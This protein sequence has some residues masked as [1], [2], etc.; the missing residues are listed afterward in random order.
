MADFWGGFGKGFAPAYE[1]AFTSAERRR[2]KREAEIKRLEEARLDRLRKKLKERADQAATVASYGGM[3]VKG[4]IPERRELPVSRDPSVV[5]GE[6]E[7]GITPE[8]ITPRV[9][10]EDAVSELSDAEL[11]TRSK[12]GPL[13]YTEMIAERDKTRKRMEEKASE[14]LDSVEQQGRQSHLTPDVVA[15]PIPDTLKDLVTESD[16]KRRFSM[17]AQKIAEAGKL[18]VHDAATTMANTATKYRERV[19]KALTGLSLHDPGTDEFKAEVDD[20]MKSLHDDEAAEDYLKDAEEHKGLLAILAVHQRMAEDD[21]KINAVEFKEATRNLPAL[22]EVI[23]S[24]KL[25]PEAKT[26]A[27]KNVQI[28]FDLAED[29]RN[30][31]NAGIAKDDPKWIKAQAA[32]DMHTA[33]THS[34]YTINYNLNDKGESEFSLKQTGAKKDPVKMIFQDMAGGKLAAFAIVN[35]MLYLDNTEEGRRALK[36][37]EEVRAKVQESLADKKGSKFYILG[38]APSVQGGPAPVDPQEPVVPE[39]IPKPT[40]KPIPEPMIDKSKPPTLEESTTNLSRLTPAERDGRAKMIMSQIKQKLP[41]SRQDK[42]WF[43]EEKRLGA[44][45][46]IK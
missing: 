19:S 36:E 34:G 24:L 4:M 3:G 28:A 31:H 8:F 22:R 38:A 35:P 10:V 7:V 1:T 43:Y 5:T 2:E 45:L 6:G 32:M 23:K 15:P 25:T 20:K 39:P 26:A 44:L 9:S 21:A 12:L 46:D 29:L 16:V 14:F 18:K 37:A 41:L 17:G 40:P 27:Q 30:L 13:L 33:L 42:R 11:L